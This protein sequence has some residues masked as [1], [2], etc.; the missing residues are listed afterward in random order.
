MLTGDNMGGST[1][2]E[3]NADGCACV[4]AVVISIMLDIKALPN[5][6]T[7]RPQSKRQ[8]TSSHFRKG[9]SCKELSKSKRGK[10]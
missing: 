9:S 5:R 7:L 10:T 3:L 4:N 1:S 6:E 8:G 2:N